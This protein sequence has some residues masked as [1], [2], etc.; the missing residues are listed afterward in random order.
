MQGQSGRCCNPSRGMMKAYKYNLHQIPHEIGL[1][2]NT[3]LSTQSLH[4]GRQQYLAINEIDE[5]KI[6]ELEAKKTKLLFSK[7]FL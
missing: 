5:L 6:T 7:S 4:T 1:Q 2:I 3:L